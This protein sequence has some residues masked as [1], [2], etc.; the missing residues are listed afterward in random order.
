MLNKIIIII[1]L[2]FAAQSAFAAPN[3]TY[4]IVQPGQ[5][6]VNATTEPQQIKVRQY[7]NQNKTGY[8]KARD[9]MYITTNILSDVISNVRA[10][11]SMFGYGLGY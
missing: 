9:T 6:Y 8:E 11:T 7:N 5:I 10:I 4:E 3:Y 1:A 2:L